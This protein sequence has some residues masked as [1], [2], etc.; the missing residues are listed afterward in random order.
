MGPRGD[1]QVGQATGPPRVPA[2]DGIRGVAVAAVVA[3]HLGIH[4]IRG[5][6]LGVDVFFVLSGYLITGLVL[7]EWR[8]TGDVSLVRF[9]GRR[10]RRLLP[11]LLLVLIVVAL[12]RRAGLSS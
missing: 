10:S 8:L 3:F 7:N 5:G 2:L 4:Q 6:L 9:L 1:P 11:A 12:G